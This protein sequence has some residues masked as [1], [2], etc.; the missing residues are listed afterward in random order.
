MKE[1]N[2]LNNNKKT[3]YFLCVLVMQ[4]A[5]QLPRSF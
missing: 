3:K 2:S 4:A 5:R 1:Y